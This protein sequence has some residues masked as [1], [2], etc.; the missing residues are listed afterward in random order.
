ML[1]PAYPRNVAHNSPPTDELSFMTLQGEGLSIIPEF[2]RLSLYGALPLLIQAHEKRRFATGRSILARAHG[3]PIQRRFV[4]RE[5]DERI[6]TD[7]CSDGNH[8]RNQEDRRSIPHN[9]H[10]CVYPPWS[11]VGA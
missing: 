7:L 6:S 3:K 1:R 5:F 9:A 11:C 2:A 10:R 4:H 8:R